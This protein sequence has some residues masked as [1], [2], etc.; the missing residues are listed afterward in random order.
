MKIKYQQIIGAF[1][2]GILIPFLV[3]RMGGMARPGGNEETTSGP[4]ETETVSTQGGT[5]P[6]LGPPGYTVSVYMPGGEIVQMSMESYLTGVIL[7]EMST[8]YEIAALQAQAVAARTYAL[9]RQGEGRHPGGAVCTDPN[10][11]QAYVGV[12]EYLDGLGY[13]VDIDR[14]HQAAVTTQGEVVTFEGTCIE[15]TYFSCAGG[16]TEDAAAVWG[17]SYPYLQAVESPEENDKHHMVRLE[18]SEE[19]LEEKLGRIL[20]GTPESWLGWTTYT[21]GGGVDTVFFGGQRYEGT[22]FRSLLGLASTAFTLEPTENGICITTYG[23]G[24]RVGMSQCGAQVMALSGSTYQEILLHYYK[25]VSLE[26]LDAMG[27]S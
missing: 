24:H 5:E 21:P 4:Q 17:V 7:A 20:Y 3:F 18:L 19:E 10:C 16:K 14:A 15:A 26:S 9:R 2:L 25:G 22:E 27:I 13:Q 6:T 12:A 11:C 1:V 8:N 23:K